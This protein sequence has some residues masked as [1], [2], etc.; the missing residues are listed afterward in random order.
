MAWKQHGATNPL[1]ARHAGDWAM[2]GASVALSGAAFGL[3]GAAVAAALAAP[4]IV[5][6][7]GR[8]S[9]AEAGASAHPG[10]AGDAVTGL[11]LRGQMLAALDT[12]FARAPATGRTTACFVAALDNPGELMSRLGQ[13]GFERVLARVAGGLA[14]A[15]REPDMVARIEGARFG[16]ALGPVRRLDLEAAIQIAAR[17][18]AAVARPVSL[19]AMSVHVTASVGFCLFSRAPERTGEAILAAAERA[20]EE[21]GYNG[22]AAIRAYSAEIAQAAT[23]RETMRDAVEGALEDGQIVGWFQ[24]QLSTD[25][26]AVSGYEILARWVHPTRGVL[27]PSEFLP[28]IEGAGLMGRLSEIMLFH[29]LTAIKAWDRAGHMVPTV[30]V[31]FSKEELR[32]PRLAG[33][34]QWELDRFELPPARITIEV[35]ESVVADTDNDVVVHNIAALARMGCRIDLDD[36]GTGNASI[37]N[38]RRFDVHRI[39]IDRSFV[40]GIDTDAG[41]QRMLSAILSMAERLDIATLAEG[42]ERVGE[43]AILSQLGCGH[44]QGFG[45]ARPM[46]FD[47]T[48]TWLERHAAKL[49]VT[50]RLG[51]K[52]G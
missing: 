44:V 18:Q 16:V 7:R 47:D 49:A 37:A 32:D 23:D 39:K 25:T 36:F 30:A 50:P 48:L 24:P 20:C 8:R 40:T 26:G 35:L 51:R 12:A 13:S 2:L 19:D 17:L 46:P 15:M 45:I 22:P 21:A 10:P 6:G 41:Q 31:N 11:P 29:A 5:I 27:P 34:L 1:L 4:A 33:R 52:T 28:A 38:I 14:D 3:S 9:A 43:H 42:V